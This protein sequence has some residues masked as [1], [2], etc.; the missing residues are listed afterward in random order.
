MKKSSFIFG[1]S[2]QICTMISGIAYSQATFQADD[3]INNSRFFIENKGQWPSEV[4]FCAEIDG[5]KAWITTKGVTFDFYRCEKKI[6]NCKDNM[7]SCQ[8]KTIDIEY[9]KSGQV[10]KMLYGNNENDFEISEIKQRETYFNYFIGNDSTK[11]ESNIRII[12]QFVIKDLYPGVDQRW[13]FDST[14]IRYDFIVN[15]GADYSVIKFEFFGTDEYFISNNKLLIKTRFGNVEN[16][17]LFVYQNIYGVKQKVES[18]WEISNGKVGF[19]IEN[20]D[21]SFPLIIDPLVFCTY[22]GGGDFD[23]INAIAIDN[24][25]NPI[26]VGYAT[27]SDFPTTTGAYDQSINYASDFFVSKFNKTGTDLTFSTFIG[28]SSNDE[29]MSI[30]LDKGGDFFISGM[31]K[32]TNFPTTTGSFQPVF[33]GGL[34]DNVVV[35]LDS[36]GSALLYST[37]LGGSGNEN[38]SSIVCDSLHNVYICGYTNSTNFPISVGAFQSANAGYSDAFVTKLDSSGSSIL[39]STYIGGSSGEVCYSIDLDSDNNVYITGAA[40]TGFPVTSGSF[41]TTCNNGDAFISKLNNTGTDLIYSTF[42]GGNNG[43][44]LGR[45]IAVNSNGEAIITGYSSGAGFP[46]TPG[47]FQPY[48]NHEGAFVAKINHL[49]S[50][51]LFAT[52][53]GNGESTKIVID[54]VGNSIITGYT[55]G[56][57]FPITSNAFDTLFNGGTT[58]VFVSKLTPDGSS[59][60]YSTFLGSTYG[61]EY[62]YSLAVDLYGDV[63]VG[64]FTEGFNFPVTNGAFQNE[65]YGIV[66]GFLFKLDICNTIPNLTVSASP[67]QICNIDTV[68]LTATGCFQYFWDHGLGTGASHTIVS[69]G[70]ETF[71][72]IGMDSFGCSDTAYLYIPEV[73]I[74]TNLTLHNDTLICNQNNASYQWVICPSLNIITGA[75]EQSL[76]APDSGSYAVVISFSGC[77][78]T[79]TCYSVFASID[80]QILSNRIQVMPNPNDGSFVILSTENDLIEILDFTGKTIHTCQIK[81]MTSINL[82]VLPGVYF[83]KAR[84]CSNVLKILI[85]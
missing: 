79:T 53:L 23:E 39:F 85:Y 70:D 77:T 11:W 6:N 7:I 45:S 71:F 29:G 84:N 78:D 41:Q 30:A 50:A 27:S 83:L 13:Y 28:G 1:L 44:D 8:N 19:S 32:S 69:G 14:N 20:Y 74:D 61:N 76:I 37:Y 59:L 46:V 56:V 16:K 34:Y 15:P 42:L 18:N 33:G 5:G 24:S 40:E 12:D 80:D 67:M 9:L 49:G 31:T 4:L 35:K 2:F 38:Y 55:V 10:I 36:S 60:I 48:P 22:L 25:G 21:T 54:S 3:K 73:L 47:S 72:I 51:L 66:N 26:V 81:E 64:G 62:S 75:T 63:Y 82:A 68:T 65:N 58:D 17:D 43:G 57:G 52:F